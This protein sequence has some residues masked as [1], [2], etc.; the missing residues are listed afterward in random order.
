MC[1]QFQPKKYVLFL[2]EFL[3]LYFLII[4]IILCFAFEFWTFFTI[5]FYLLQFLFFILTQTKASNDVYFYED[6]EGVS[7]A[8]EDGAIRSSAIEAP[9]GRKSLKFHDDTH[10]I[11]YEGQRTHNRAG[12]PMSANYDLQIFPWVCLSIC[13]C[14]LISFSTNLTIFLLR[15]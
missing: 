6:Y 1:I 15:H 13:I 7:T 5:L 3:L 2:I 10:M 9:C 14:V 8:H 12:S 11:V 4:S